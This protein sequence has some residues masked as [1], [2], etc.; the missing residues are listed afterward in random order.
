MA[1]KTKKT[2]KTTKATKTT[3][4]AKKATPPAKTSRASM[5]APKATAKKTP[6][7]SFGWRFFWVLVCAVI[8]SC[9]I[10]AVD[11]AIFGTSDRIIANYD[12]E[13]TIEVSEDISVPTSLSWEEVV[14]ER[15]AQDIFVP[16]AWGTLFTLVEVYIL[17][18]ARL[19][20][21]NATSAILIAALWLLPIA[22]AVIRL[23][24][25]YAYSFQ[26]TS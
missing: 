12:S 16:I 18:K 15:L 5:K 19:L 4:T 23:V 25:C 2:T 10:I 8:S 20:G 24:S 1:T 13:Q 21:R 7:A 17:F 14:T 6:V 11:D 3:K 22:L 26:I 9:L